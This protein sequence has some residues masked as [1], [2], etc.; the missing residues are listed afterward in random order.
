[1]NVSTVTDIVPKRL[2][3]TLRDTP[4]E[5]L[6]WILHYDFRTKTDISVPTPSG[7][8]S[9]TVWEDWYFISNILDGE[10]YEPVL[11]KELREEF[12]KSSVF[13]D[14]GSRWGLFSMYAKQCGVSPG[15]IHAF[16]AD[17]RNYSLLAENHGKDG[18]HRNQSFVGDTSE[19]SHLRIDDY[20][21]LYEPPSIM[22]VD[23]EGAESDVLAGAIRTLKSAQPIIFI[24]IHPEMLADSGTTPEDVFSILES[25]GYNISI[26]LENRSNTHQWVRLETASLPNMGDY[27]IKGIPT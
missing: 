19:P 17:S 24:E 22:K 23:V 2:K 8:L 27:L 21:S 13:Y 20:T 9:M 1:M 11:M 14:I 7:P 18:T 15:Q 16:E 10:M 25:A 3:D 6:Y 5:H 26:C 4:L 12:D